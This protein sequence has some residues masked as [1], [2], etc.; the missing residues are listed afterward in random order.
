MKAIGYCLSAQHFADAV[1]GGEEEVTFFK[2]VVDSERG[3]DCSF[4][5]ERC[6]QRL[7]AMVAGAHGD[8]EFVK[9]HPHVVVVLVADKE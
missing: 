5:A 2:G 7:G 8:T 6:H 1:E 9:E 3:A 4:D